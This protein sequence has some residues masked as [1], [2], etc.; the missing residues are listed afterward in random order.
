[1]NLVTL[2]DFKRNVNYKKILKTNS[3]GKIRQLK[4]IFTNNQKTKKDCLVFMSILV[5][6]LI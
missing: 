2:L 4:K 3:D 5:S 6:F 1:M